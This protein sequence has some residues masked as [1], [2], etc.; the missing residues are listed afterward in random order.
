[1][2]KLWGNGTNGAGKPN[3]L[4]AGAND[5]R[6]NQ[7]DN[8]YATAAGWVLRHPDG[9]EELL[10]AIRGLDLGT[11][12]LGV[13]V[14]DSVT[15]SGSKTHGGTGMVK[16]RFNEQVAV[17]GNPTLLVST[18][19]GGPTVT[20]TYASMNSAKTVLTFNYT[21]PAAGAVVS[22]AAQSVV[23]AGG[24]TIKHAEAGEAVPDNAT[25][26]ISSGLATAAGNYTAL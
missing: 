24:S 11:A 15:F 2:A 7:L 20:A 21:V 5:G 16:V 19:V 13:P 12:K 23:L 18:T 26:T 22:I 1:M 17:T 4:T 14:I 10:V 3:W 25:L 6:Y 8:C 9:T